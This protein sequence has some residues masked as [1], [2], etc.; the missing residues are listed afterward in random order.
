MC[1]CFKHV[2]LHDLHES[3]THQISSQFIDKCCGL[4]ILLNRD[5]DANKCP[6]SF[7][8]NIYFKSDMYLSSKIKGIIK[9]LEG[10]KKRKKSQ[11]WLYL[12]TESKVPE[13]N[14]RIQRIQ[15]IN[16]P[17]T[18]PKGEN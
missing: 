15:R 9:F 16:S 2:I 17:V 3:P 18:E 12:I 11:S 13:P 14:L 7:Q 6:F 10:K 4:K 5:T 8:F 1:T